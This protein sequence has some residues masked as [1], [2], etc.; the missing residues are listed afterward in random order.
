MQ[1]HTHIHQYPHAQP[2]NIIYGNI[3]DIYVPSQWTPTSPSCPHVGSPRGDNR[4]QSKRLLSSGLQFNW[5][6]KIGPVPLRKSTSDT[7]IRVPTCPKEFIYLILYMVDYHSVLWGAHPW[8]RM[9]SLYQNL[10]TTSLEY[11]LLTTYSCEYIKQHYHK[12]PLSENP[13]SVQTTLASSSSNRLLQT[14]PQALLMQISTLPSRTLAPSTSLN[15]PS[16][17]SA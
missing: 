9:F 15:A 13:I 11:I 5:S 1:M 8:L 2:H 4:L 17:Q 12:V 16:V 6:R 10:Q 14:V 7:R 3:I